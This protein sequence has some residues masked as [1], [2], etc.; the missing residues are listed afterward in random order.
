VLKL[1]SFATLFLACT[2]LLSSANAQST[3]GS[4]V[5]VVHDSTQAVV[6]GASLKIRSLED[7]SSR[8][9]TADENGSFEFVNLK[10]GHYAISAQAAGFS[11]FQVPSAELT[12]RQTLRIDVT[13]GVKSQS[14][15]V[16]VADTVAVINT[17]RNV[18]SDDAGQSL[19]RS[20]RVLPQLVLTL[21][22][23]Q[24]RQSKL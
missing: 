23:L 20:A 9:A 24:C 18:V 7:N 13:M 5:G 14:E 22:H 21:Q 19:C 11:D 4:I 1:F 10:P 12:A 3:F 8:A 17:E 15:T 16:E 6:P 2:V